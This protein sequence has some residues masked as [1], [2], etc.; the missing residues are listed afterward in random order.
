MHGKPPLGNS[1]AP[2]LGLTLLY[3]IFPIFQQ[4]LVEDYPLSPRI[5]G[6]DVE[7]AGCRT[8]LFVCEHP[9]SKQNLFVIFANPL[10]Q[11]R[12]ERLRG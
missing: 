10:K 9:R 5:A 1:P 3:E 12:S 11:V 2:E 4:C 6:D 8:L 7:E